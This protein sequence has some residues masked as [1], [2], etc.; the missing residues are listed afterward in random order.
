MAA[1][2]AKALAEELKRQAALNAEAA[3]KRQTEL[4]IARQKRASITAQRL[5]TCNFWKDQYLKTN[6]SYD[7]SMRDMAC[8]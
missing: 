3:K 2:K 4:E 6:S 8:M 7:K 1:S 5:R